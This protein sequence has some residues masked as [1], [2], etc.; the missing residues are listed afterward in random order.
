MNTNTNT[1]IHNP[2]HPTLL[3]KGGGWGDVILFIAFVL[4]E[5]NSLPQSPVDG[6]KECISFAPIS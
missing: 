3:L 5:N 6:H 2:P 1:L 4:I